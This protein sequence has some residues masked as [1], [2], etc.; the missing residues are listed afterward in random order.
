[1]K[2]FCKWFPKRRRLCCMSFALSS[3]SQAVELGPCI[4]SS[5]HSMPFG[6][7]RHFRKCIVDLEIKKTK[8]Q[9]KNGLQGKT[10]I[11]TCW[12]WIW[13]DLTQNYT[14]WP[15]FWKLPSCSLWTL[16]RYAQSMCISSRLVARARV[17][18]CVCVGGGVRVDVGGGVSVCC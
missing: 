7:G 9:N 8:K 12:F 15:E 2:N 18:A 17:R 14:Q 6:T 1:M 13:F 16:S 10:L 5:Y 11:I 3:V 4:W